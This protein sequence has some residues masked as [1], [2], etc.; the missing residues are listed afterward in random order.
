M[1]SVMKFR[2]STSSALTARIAL[3]LLCMSAVFKV[4]PVLGGT[5]VKFGGSHHYPPFHYYAQDG[6]PS[7]FDV[8]VFQQVADAAG[9]AT[10]YKL[11]DWSEIQN[12]LKE[13]LVD[14]VPMFVSDGRKEKYFFSNPIN[15]EY[16]LLFG[17]LGL[18]SHNDL[19]SLAGRRI[20]AEIGAFATAELQRLDQDIE[21]ISAK[22][23]RDALLMVTHGEA[24]Y[25]LLPSQIG[26]RI[27]TGE[28]LEG[29]AIL[30]PPVLPATY[31]FA[32]NPK[33]PE[34]VA[35]VNSAIEQMQRSG[36]LY[37]LSNQWLLPNG[38]ETSIGSSQFGK[39]F[40]LALA[41]LCGLM[42]A[43][44][45]Y[46]RVQFGR[47]QGALLSRDSLVR[48][49]TRK[50]K[51][52][53]N[54]DTLTGLPNRKR[55]IRHVAVSLAQSV[56]QNGNVAVGIVT[57]HNL[58]TIQDILDDSAGDRLVREFSALVETRTDL[59]PAYLGQGLF[60]FLFTSI[61]DRNDAFRKMQNLITTLS[62]DLSVRGILVHTQLSGGMAI[63]PVDAESASD[64][65]QRAKLAVNNA[66]KS[67]AQLLFF[68]S[69]M[70]PDP[71]KLQLISDLKMSIA[72]GELSWALQPQYSV[73]A[74]K[75]IGAEMLIRWKHPEYGWVPPC[76]F[77]VW[78][79]QNGFIQDITEAAVANASKLMSQF[80]SLNRDCRISVNL[81]ANDLASD[82]M[83]DRIIASTREYW[84][85][86]TLE[87]TETALMRD[88]QHVAKNVER[89]KQAG[90]HI[91]LDD[92]GTGYSS[93]EYL[94]AFHFDE[95]KIDRMFVKDIARVERNRKLAQVSIDLGHQLGAIVVAEG[96]ED[97]ESANMLID[98]GCD[99]LQGYFIG[100]PVIV[101]DLEDYLPVVDAIRL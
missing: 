71:Q 81:S 96:V 50:I 67:G 54:T 25:A 48:D 53:Y 59:H 57:L 58:D 20:A 40:V 83:V 46:Y 30:S 75:V 38:A 100:K 94:Q 11:G 42:F 61:S 85:S 15:V 12:E 9:W 14:I 23:E 93:L 68:T 60:G 55:F 45:W 51:N 22:S 18:S 4:L 87:I 29:I 90:V 70:Q 79:E 33:R 10:R 95:I 1:T 89:L 82:A 21:I 56:G 73:S 43:G 65:F 80:K 49:A 26:R 35:Q 63:Y 37:S 86:L 97:N 76:D 24:D 5:E 2:A 72:A 3:F 36:Q 19:T 39:W 44:F 16:H 101:D 98:M 47:I 41:V 62:Q 6:Q 32:I 92:Y 77:I 64:L 84:S 52:L 31:A 17:P 88:V 7:G 78:A 13:G 27:L 99:V 8:A 66:R 69:S 34:L 74:R 91:S 28:E